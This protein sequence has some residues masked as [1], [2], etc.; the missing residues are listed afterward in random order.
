[1]AAQHRR[2]ISSP[3]PLINVAAAQNVTKNQN[4]AMEAIRL[5]KKY[6]QVTQSEMFQLIE[7]FK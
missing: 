4:P 3:N 2:G 7:K 6:P 1:V 5:Q